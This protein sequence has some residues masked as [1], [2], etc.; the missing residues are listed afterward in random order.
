MGILTEADQRHAEL[1]AKTCDIT[2]RSVSTPIESDNAGEAA[3]ALPPERATIYRACVARG[4]YIAQ[5]RSDRQYA[6]KE[7]SRA[8]ANP[9]TQDEKRLHRLARYL[10]DKSRHQVVFPLLSQLEWHRLRH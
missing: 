8:M 7:L 5:D 9:S 1:I 2:G 6:V 3:T 10:L 4:N